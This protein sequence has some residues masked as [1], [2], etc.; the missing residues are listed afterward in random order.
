MIGAVVPARIF[1]LVVSEIILLFACFLAAAYTD[2]DVGDVGVFLLYDSGVLRIAIAVGLIV[3]GLFFK[4][5]YADVRIHGRLVLF[6]DLCIVF[7]LAFI[8]QGVIGYI[9]SDWIIPRKMMLPGSILA[10][11]VIFGWRLFFDRAARNAV[12]AGRVLFLGMS[13][14]VARIAGHFAQH[15]EL[16]LVTIGYLESGIDA[17]S[18]PIAKLGNMAN[19]EGVLEQSVPNS[20]VIG[21]RGDIQPW[22]ADEFLALRFG[23][24]R[25]QEAGTLY[26][27]IFARKCIT[28]IWPS[29]AIFSSA[30]QPASI[31][32]GLQSLYSWPIALAAALITL[33]L[34][35]PIAA[36]IK[37]GSRGP[38]LTRETRVGL[39]DAT[40]EA[41]RFR[42][43]GP[44]GVVTPVGR[45]LRRYG[46]V[47]L[48]QLLNILK[49]Q[50]A[51]VGPRPERPL[52]ARRMNELIPVYRQRHRVK[53]GITGWARIHRQRGE[54][55]DSLKDLEFDL[56][57]LENLSPLLDFFILLL[58]LKTVERPG[59]SAA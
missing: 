11:A 55:Q 29:R 24:V 50:M 41:Y 52:F 2:P 28:E 25:V 51:M 20:I 21:N 5:L 57:Y 7:G 8:G 22:W 58:S 13:P 38:V 48:P 26:E 18:S 6:Q 19:L 44:D 4:N 43:V 12:A 35:L 31:D 53:P 34:T 30:S 40:F 27:S 23:G 59:D 15:P 36:L 46:L 10:G 32:I 54:A 47:W 56:Y 39:H 16:G 45:F 14:T 37:T 17:P 42:C 3:L 33:P 49:G 1:T 9:N